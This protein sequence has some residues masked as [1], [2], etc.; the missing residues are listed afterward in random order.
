LK[1]TGMVLWFDGR[2]KRINEGW[3]KLEAD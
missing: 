2:A 3:S 1:T